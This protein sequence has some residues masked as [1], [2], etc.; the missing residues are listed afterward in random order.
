MERLQPTLEE[1][2]NAWVDLTLLDASQ[3]P[4]I[5]DLDLLPD[6][7][8][9]PN[10]L[11]HFDYVKIIK[12]EELL[13]YALYTLKVLASMKIYKTEF[14]IDP[15]IVNFDK[16]TRLKEKIN[17]ALEEILQEVIEENKITLE[18]D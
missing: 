9:N 1:F 13:N 8:S 17:S 7:T 4:E 11:T 6:D 2:R 15:R 3:E 14:N 12:T 18:N 10:N 16:A 5:M